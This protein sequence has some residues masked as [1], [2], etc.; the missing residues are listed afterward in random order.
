[1]R[2]LKEAAEV[3]EL[4]QGRLLELVYRLLSEESDAVLK[5]RRA[6]VSS[7]GHSH[8]LAGRIRQFTVVTICAFG[9]DNSSFLPSSYSR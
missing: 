6:R 8:F 3:P 4:S 9:S 1:M 5:V 7:G 2:S